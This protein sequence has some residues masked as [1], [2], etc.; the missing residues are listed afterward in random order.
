MSNEIISK[1]LSNNGTNAKADHYRTYLGKKD[2]KSKNEEKHESSLEKF[3]KLANYNK[4][5]KLR[6]DEPAP[7]KDGERASQWEEW[8]QFIEKKVKTLSGGDEASKPLNRGY[9]DESSSSRAPPP[10]QNINKNIIASSDLLEAKTKEM[11]KKSSRNLLS[12]LTGSSKGPK[13][14]AGSNVSASSNL[15]LSSKNNRGD[16]YLAG[17][18]ESASYDSKASEELGDDDS[19]KI[20][21]FSPPPNQNKSQFQ[22]PSPMGPGGSAPTSAGDTVVPDSAQKKRMPPA[23]DLNKIG[24]APA[25]IKAPSRPGSAT[26]QPSAKKY[27]PEEKIVEE[28]E[29]AKTDAGT[30]KMLNRKAPSK[31]QGLKLNDVSR[32][33]M[34]FASSFIS[35]SS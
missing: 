32:G 21:Y 5:E 24:V 4:S 33:V 22:T 28:A 7:E 16:S 12:M 23:L 17:G 27:K 14:T 10:V 15:F 8:N 9:Q 11:K 2:D 6:Q 31:H 30:K 18:Q 35:L 25:H 3:N 29:L 20:G 26:A 34:L 19:A 1:A 13:L